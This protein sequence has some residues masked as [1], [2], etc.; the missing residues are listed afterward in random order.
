MEKKIQTIEGENIIFS[1]NNNSISIDS[2][3]AIALSLQPYL[4]HAREA[5]LPHIQ[6]LMKQEIKTDSWD[7]LGETV[8]SMRKYE[9]LFT[10]KMT[11]TSILRD[12]LLIS[13]LDY[14]SF[15]VRI[16]TIDFLTEYSELENRETWINKKLK[17]LLDKMIRLELIKSY[18]ITNIQVKKMRRV[19]IYSAP[20]SNA[21]SELWILNYYKQ[22][23]EGLGYQDIENQP[24]KAE[25]K[26]IVE[27][28][29]KPKIKDCVDCGIL[30]EHKYKA[31][32]PPEFTKSSSSHVW[33]KI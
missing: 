23:A 22:I 8:N 19:R 33:R 25:L 15:S 21:K 12:F 29:L 13:F 31:C 9:W 11:L 17:Q 16:P 18:P 6:K 4:S 28:S 27:S 7:D 2:L 32:N 10:D 30:F 24:T 26:K 5:W 14:P 20:W 3:E 1:L